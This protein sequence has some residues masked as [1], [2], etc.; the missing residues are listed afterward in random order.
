MHRFFVDGRCIERGGLSLTDENA[1]HAHVLR[2]AIGE[3]VVVCDGNGM[4]YYCTVTF[5]NKSAT[6]L[7]IRDRATNTAEP[8]MVITLYQALPKSG[9]M[10]EIVDKCTQLGISHIVPIMTSRC[11]AKMSDRDAK[12][13]K[14]WQKVA[15]SAASQSGRGRIPRIG[16]VMSF[17]AALQDSTAHDV[18]FACYEGEAQLSLKSFLQGLSG[19]PSSI[20]FFVGA[21]GG[22]TDDEMAKFLE[23]SVA[24]V[25][26]GSRVLR[27]ELAGITALACIMYEI[28]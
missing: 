3:E 14:R 17:D 13:I 23:G 20:A 24:S 10:E 21:E 1:A 9:K 5:T 18:V 25:S 15:R 8:S 22:F 4:D 19:I 27:T 28:Q 11:V 7:R 6:A 26:L 2:L 16:D 12:K